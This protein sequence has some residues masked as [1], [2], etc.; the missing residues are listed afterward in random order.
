MIWTDCDLAACIAPVLLECGSLHL[1]CVNACVCSFVYQ[2]CVVT[3]LAEGELYHIL[4]D[5]KTLPEAEVH[6]CSST[7][8]KSTLY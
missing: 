7:Y 8:I 2:I 5:D 3:E 4:Q 1:L 6:V